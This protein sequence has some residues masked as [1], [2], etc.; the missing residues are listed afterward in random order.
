MKEFYKKYDRLQEAMRNAFQNLNKLGVIP[1]RLI[2]P[3]INQNK[4]S[5]KSS[6]KEHKGVNFTLSDKD[7]NSLFTIFEIA[8]ENVSFIIRMINN[9]NSQRA[10][11]I[12]RINNQVKTQALIKLIKKA[13]NQT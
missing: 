13:V 2:E 3:L 1:Q 9:Y 11:L 8:T 7:R 5:K 4:D 6:F 10:Y 12:R